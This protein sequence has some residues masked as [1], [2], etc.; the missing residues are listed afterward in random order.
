LEVSNGTDP[1]DAADPPV[2]DADGDGISTITENQNAANFGAAFGD[3]NDASIPSNSTDFDGDTLFDRDELIG[4]NGFVTDPTQVDTDQDGI[5]DNDERVLNLP[6]FG[7]TFTDPTNPD[8][9]GDGINDGAEAQGLN[10]DY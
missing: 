2:G 1:N 4:A 7:D 10:G 5:A 6:D 9:D 3:P 8:T